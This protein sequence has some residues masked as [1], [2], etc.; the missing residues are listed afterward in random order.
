MLNFNLSCSTVLGN[1]LFPHSVN[2]HLI[3]PCIYCKNYYYYKNSNN[4]KNYYFFNRLPQQ[5]CVANVDCSIHI[6]VT[7]WLGPVVTQ[8]PYYHQSILSPFIIHREYVGPIQSKKSYGYPSYPMLIL[9]AAWE[10]LFLTVNPDFV[11]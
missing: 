4:S 6:S 8:S 11:F 2:V 3:V 1:L 9:K 7:F 10:W 5:T